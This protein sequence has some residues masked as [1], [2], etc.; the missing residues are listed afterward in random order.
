MTESAN[1]LCASFSADCG[2]VGTCDHA[3]PGTAATAIRPDATNE[4]DRVAGVHMPAFK[5]RIRLP[6]VS[7]RIQDLV[8]SPLDVIQGETHGSELNCRDAIYTGYQRTGF[9]ERC[10]RRRDLFSQELIG[11]M[12]YRQFGLASHSRVPHAMGKNV[13][14]VMEFRSQHGQA[15]ESWLWLRW[16]RHA[17]DCSR[18]DRLP[19]ASHR[20]KTS[21]DGND[22][23]DTRR[24]AKVFRALRARMSHHRVVEGAG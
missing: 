24:Q 7:A 4:R 10:T 17:A 18:A 5:S 19:A 14:G 13:S 20:G 12:V 6:T 9:S 21:D 15:A 23:R 3:L 2:G 22:R 11:Q 8:Y 1:T 16:L